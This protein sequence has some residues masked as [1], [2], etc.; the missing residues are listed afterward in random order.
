MA[1]LSLLKE[2][3][4]WETFFSWRKDSRRNLTKN[5]RFLRVPFSKLSR[6][7][8]KK[9]NLTGIKK[10]IILTRENHVPEIWIKE[11]KKKRELWIQTPYW[12]FCKR[13]FFVMYKFSL[14]RSNVAKFIWLSNSILLFYIFVL[15][16]ILCF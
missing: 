10:K 3:K 16:Q 11:R 14:Y 12:Y 2:S 15:N 4:S 8:E 6:N 13:W 9:I 7:R 5:I 1:E